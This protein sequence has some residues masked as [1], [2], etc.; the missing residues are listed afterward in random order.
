M[1]GLYQTRLGQCSNTLFILAHIC[2]V[3]F[4]ADAC[5]FFDVTRRS[6]FVAIGDLP[7]AVLLHPEQIHVK[8]LLVC[9]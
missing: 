9:A 1:L 8:R 2:I 4:H 6:T 7:S 5:V 3:C